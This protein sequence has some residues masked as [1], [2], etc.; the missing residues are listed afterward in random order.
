MHQCRPSC[1]RSSQCV[2]D[3]A[4][5]RMSRATTH[6]HRLR[7]ALEVLRR[8][9]PIQ[10][11]RTIRA[12]TRTTGM[13]LGLH[14]QLVRHG[15]LHCVREKNHQWTSFNDNEPFPR[16]LR[17]GLVVRVWMCVSR[18]RRRWHGTLARSVLL[19][20]AWRRRHVSTGSD[21]KLV[22]ENR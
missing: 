1:S 20:V 6:R 3:H 22:S 11:I 10:S 7:R 21:C 16:T 17:T 8:R 12:W 2:H 14:H 15:V 5:S 9:R 18:H 19:R 4:R 13:L